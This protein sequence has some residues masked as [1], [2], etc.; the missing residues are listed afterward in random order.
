M[1]YLHRRQKPSV[2]SA[3]SGLSLAALLAL[4][5]CAGVVE[6]SPATDRGSRR[7]LHFSDCEQGATSGCVP[8]NNLNAGTLAA[9]KQNLAGVNL[10]A[11]DAGTALLFARGGAWN[12]TAMRRLENLN[13]TAAAPLV[14]ADYGAGALPL[15]RF[16]SGQ[17]A[18]ELGGGWNN[19][20]NDGGYTFR[21]IKFDGGGVTTWGF[22]L[23]D[24]VHDVT[25]DGVEITGFAIAIH[26]QSVMPHGVNNVSILNSRIVRNSD[27]GWLGKVKAGLRV[28]GNLFEGNNFGGSGFSH[29]FYGGGGNNVIFQ[30]NRFIRNSVGPNGMCGGGSLTLHG[31][32]DGVL[33]EGNTFEQTASDN[34]C[35]Q[36]SITQ[37]Y[38]TAE[39]FRN[40]VVRGNKIVNGGNAGMVIQSA[41]NALVENNII[42]NTQTVI[43]QTAILVGGGDRTGGDDAD[44]GATVRNNTA[45]YVAPA[46]NSGVT[47]I[48]STGAVVSNNMM[49]TGSAATTGVCTR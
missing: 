14:F 12:F 31:Q 45:C 21:N 41:P 48:S 40:L 44:S 38:A 8:G 10:N 3:M 2:G 13:S 33:V 4:P 37:G 49:I 15:F 11:L 5:A 30:N 22:W 16:A 42:I 20:T 7:T 34:G 17:I 25:F 9:P 19:Q 29:A 6:A 24:N 1:I 47:R 27:M 46:R 26:S 18:F 39:W 32:Y 36:V 28:E 23:R 35:W 43:P